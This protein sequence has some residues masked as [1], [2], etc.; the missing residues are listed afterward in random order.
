MDRIE[1]QCCCIGTSYI[2]DIWFHSKTLKNVYV[3]YLSQWP[4]ILSMA[5]HSYFRYHTKIN[6]T[7]K[8]LHHNDTHTALWSPLF[9]PNLTSS[10]ILSHVTVT[11]I[12]HRN[13]RH[14]S[15]AKPKMIWMKSNQIWYIYCPR[16]IFDIPITEIIQRGLTNSRL[17]AV[18]WIYPIA[19][20]WYESGFW[21]FRGKRIFYPYPILQFHP[22]FHFPHPSCYPCLWSPFRPP[23]LTA[24]MNNYT[25]TAIPCSTSE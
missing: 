1:S 9:P 20:C 16:N 24:Y 21:M 6:K 25:F 11:I 13:F 19:V 17:I 18:G 8:T 14:K 2:G 3:M 5:E 4:C 10:S 22:T 23:S 7:L 12:A 15:Y